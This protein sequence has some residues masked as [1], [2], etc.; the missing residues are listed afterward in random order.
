M[1]S[2]VLELSGKGGLVW[3]GACVVYWAKVVKCG[4]ASLQEWVRSSGGWGG[5]VDKRSGSVEEMVRLCGGNGA[6]R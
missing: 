5:F 1:G 4:V 6:V 3:C 2:F